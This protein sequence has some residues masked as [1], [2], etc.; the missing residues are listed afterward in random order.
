MD[1]SLDDW[2]T[3]CLNA[4]TQTLNSRLRLLQYNWV[5]RTY[6][7]PVRLNKFNPNI[8]DLCFKCNKLQGTFFHCVWECEEVQK[9]WVGVTQYVSQFTS[10]LIPLCPV[11]CVLSM[12][13]DNCTLSTKERKL[14]DLCLL[15]AIRSIA[16]CWK[17]TICH[18]IGLWLKNLITCSA[19]EKLTYI[20]RKKPSAFSDIWEVFLNFVKNGDIEEAL[21]VMEC[22]K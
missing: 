19:L 18:S 11:L 4:Q 16:P 12:Y 22:K 6:I 3:I 10:S 20:I 15:Q 7:T 5:M 17:N 14:V 1:I 9:F 8:P 2:N 13:E 21:D